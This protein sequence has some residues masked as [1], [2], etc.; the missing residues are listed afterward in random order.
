MRSTASVRASVWGVLLGGNELQ[1]IDNKQYSHSD[2]ATEL[3]RYD[4]T[5]Y[6]LNLCWQLRSMSLQPEKASA[7]ALAQGAFGF[8]LKGS[9]I[10]RQGE[11]PSRSRGN[12]KQRD[13][14]VSH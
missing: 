3:H 12:V 8:R 11:S 13:G 4:A 9:L 6:G 5:S 10:R 7:I 1:A 2:P 14:D